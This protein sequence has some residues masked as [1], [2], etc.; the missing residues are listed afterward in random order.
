[1]IGKKMQEFAKLGNDFPIQCR[2]YSVPIWL[3]VRF[4]RRLSTM[5]LNLT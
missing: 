4:K 2:V 1:M 5:G 3:F